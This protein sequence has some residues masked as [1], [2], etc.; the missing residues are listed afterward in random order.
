MVYGVSCYC[1]H[2][3]M[4]HVGSSCLSCQSGAC[5]G[6]IRNQYYPE[7]TERLLAIASPSTHRT[8]PVREHHGPAILHFWRW[9]H[10][11][12]EKAAA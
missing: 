4:E 7:R 5:K 1:G 2:D 6:F 12:Q 8:E 3:T 9:H 11:E 10:G